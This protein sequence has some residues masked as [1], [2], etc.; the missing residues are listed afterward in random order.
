FQIIGRGPRKPYLEKRV[1][2]KNLPNCQFLSF[3]SDE[4]FP[5]SLSA[6]DIGVVILDEKT[7]KGSV[8]SK[9]YNLMSYGIPSLYIASEDSQLKIYT[10][11]YNHGKCFSKDD[12]SEIKEYILQLAKNTDLYHEISLNAEKASNDFRRINA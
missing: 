7:S 5:Y 2:E 11:K 9:S 6:A 10:E 8:P 4:M 3:Q 12:L 1:E